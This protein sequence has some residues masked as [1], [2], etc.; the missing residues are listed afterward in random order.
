MYACFALH[1]IKIRIG[2]LNH[3]TNVSGGFSSGYGILLTPELG[4][5]S[6][7]WRQ[8]SSFKGA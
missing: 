5:Q 1:L 3:V 7:M 4:Q 8:G 2:T 6:N